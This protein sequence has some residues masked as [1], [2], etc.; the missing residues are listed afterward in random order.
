MTRCC[1]FHR[2][3]RLTRRRAYFDALEYHR[4]LEAESVKQL[5]VRAAMDFFFCS[6]VEGQ[7]RRE[8]AL[9]SYSKGW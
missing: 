7:R 1:I 8:C 5:F 9:E 6:E 4:F 3:T 2:N